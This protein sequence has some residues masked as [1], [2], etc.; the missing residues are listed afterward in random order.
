ME[1][2]KGWLRPT[3][4]EC[5]SKP[6]I[7][8]RRKSDFLFF[9][10]DLTSN[11]RHC[12][13]RRWDPNDRARKC[14]IWCPALLGYLGTSSLGTAEGGGGEADSNSGVAQI[15][16]RVPEK[17]MPKLGLYGLD[18]LRLLQCRTFYA[19]FAWLYLNQWPLVVFLISRVVV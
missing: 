11:Y 12:G 7:T 2:M 16:S 15:C 3:G 10:S 8:H 5:L 4:S 18:I 14:E 9:G 6:L 19:T 1:K 13:D 17:I